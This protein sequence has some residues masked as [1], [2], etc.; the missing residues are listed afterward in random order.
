MSVEFW[1]DGEKFGTQE[2][3]RSEEYSRD[4]EV[5]ALVG[6]VAAEERV[7]YDRYRFKETKAGEPPHEDNN[8][9]GQTYVVDSRE[10]DTK[11]TLANGKPVAP[12]ELDRLEELHGELGVADRV[13]TELKDQT[14]AIGAKT[15]M[16]E[17]LFRAL[18][19]TAQGDFKSG[20]ITLAGKRVENGREVAVF[21]WTAEMHNEEQTGLETTWH[22]KGQALIG[23][24]PAQV[25][26]T[27]MS[28]DID[29]GGHTK[30]DGKRID[31]EGS[32]T[33]RDERSVTSL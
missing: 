4:G 13:V 2:T 20:E 8:L 24:T 7:H 29:V 1:Q 30:R 23:V 9:E 32:G 27:T 18:A 31:L 10:A 3:L 21:D 12:E 17:R 16:R 6:G 33:M 15:T 14:I 19:T 25:L 5:L 11:A 26:K 28:A 22:I